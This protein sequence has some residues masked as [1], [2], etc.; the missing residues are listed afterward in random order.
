MLQQ[1]RSAWLSVPQMGGRSAEQA[2][3]GMLLQH[4]VSPPF[5]VR[6]LGFLPSSSS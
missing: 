6:L 1:C 5:Q 4:G 2:R 3:K